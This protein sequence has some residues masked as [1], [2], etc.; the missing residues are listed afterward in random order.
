MTRHLKK[1]RQII[2]SL[3]EGIWI[4]DEND[5][6]IFVNSHMA[7]MLGYTVDEMLG[8]SL[9]SFMDEYGMAITTRALER[10]KQGI[11]EQYDCNHPG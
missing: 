1:H 2:E 7:E 9:F 10:Q 11:K 8:K 4:I 6:T 5:N 3:H